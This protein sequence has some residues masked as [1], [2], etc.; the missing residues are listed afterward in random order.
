M[1]FVIL[2]AACLFAGN[3]YAAPQMPKD[4][5]GKWCVDDIFTS[6]TATVGTKSCIGLNEGAAYIVSPRGYFHD[7]D[8]C[9]VVK[10]R[11]HAA[12]PWDDSFRHPWLGPIYHLAFKCREGDMEGF[13]PGIIKQRWQ[14]VGE[15]LEI[16]R[17]LQ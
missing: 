8:H 12:P 2:L 9:D 13:N 3:A 11:K 1:R 17:S 6:N 10:I 5:Q 7:G 15:R 16:K 14:T 4:L